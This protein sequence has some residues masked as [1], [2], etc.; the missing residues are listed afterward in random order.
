M[1]KMKDVLLVTHLVQAVMELDGHHVLLVLIDFWSHK[2]ELVLVE[3]TAN[4][5]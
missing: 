4:Q 2:M 5:S 3:T 1:F